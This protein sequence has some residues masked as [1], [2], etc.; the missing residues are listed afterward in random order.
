MNPRQEPSVSV[1]TKL[2]LDRNARRLGLREIRRSVIEQ[3]AQK[4]HFGYDS[5]NYVVS[6]TVWEHPPCLDIDVL[7][8]TSGEGEMKGAGPCA[9]VDDAVARLDAFARWLEIDA[10]NY[11]LER[12]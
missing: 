11:R 9:G 12:P 8:K 5:T 4:A 10:S 1:A 3:T 2:W 7:N 6:I